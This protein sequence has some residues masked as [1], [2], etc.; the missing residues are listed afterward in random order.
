MPRGQ[1]WAHTR[2]GLRVPT[3]LPEKEEN[4]LEDP[5]VGRS[6]CGVTPETSQTTASFSHASRSLKSSSLPC[7]GNRAGAE[8]VT[9]SVGQT[10]NFKSHEVEGRVFAS[11]FLSFS[12][13]SSSYFVFFC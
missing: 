11:I 5:G 6:A 4:E 3:V 13:F 9:G 12:F 8:R 10:G 1:V 7:P 2:H